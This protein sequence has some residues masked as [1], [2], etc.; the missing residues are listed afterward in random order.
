[1]RSCGLGLCSGI[2]LSS[3][4]WLSQS[5]ILPGELPGPGHLR[6]GLL[7]RT[8]AI[9]KD[10]TR[11]QPP[12]LGVDPV[13]C[14]PLIHQGNHAPANPVLRGW[15]GV[16][17]LLGKGPRL[18]WSELGAREVLPKGCACFPLLLPVL[19]L[20][21]EGRPQG[22]WVLAWVRKL[23]VKPERSRSEIHSVQHTC[24]GAGLGKD[25]RRQSLCSGGG[26]GRAQGLI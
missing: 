10:A 20:D 7:S 14:L 3:P 11:G 9:P 25:G 1:M 26:V 16:A 18:S 2:G 4:S 23:I 6:P 19:A 22:L 8:P 17:R 21:M 15:D 12:D 13:A 5:Q 24:L